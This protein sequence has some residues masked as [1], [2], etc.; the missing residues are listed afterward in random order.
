MRLR[1]AG[2]ARGEKR[3]MFRNSGEGPD[4]DR[5]SE[6]KFE[7]ETDCWGKRGREQ[8]GDLGTQGETQ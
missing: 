6:V 2:M 1:G 4:I 7:G 5:V 8:G 3:W